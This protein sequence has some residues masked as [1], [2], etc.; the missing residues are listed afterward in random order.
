[1]KH[2]KIAGLCIMNRPGNLGDHSGTGTCS[3]GGAKA[4][5]I[6]GTDFITSEEGWAIM[7]S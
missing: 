1:M 6:E 7:V 3:M 2:L 4:G 5:E